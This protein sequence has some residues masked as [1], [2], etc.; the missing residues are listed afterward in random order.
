MATGQATAGLSTAGQAKNAEQSELQRI[1][2]RIN[3]VRSR[4]CDL[5]G[6]AARIAESLC[7]ENPPETPDDKAP[8]EV[9]SGHLGVLENNVDDLDKQ[10]DHLTRALARITNGLKV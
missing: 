3:S 8:Q 2:E 7:G 9:R 10:V 6:I 5:T 1:T 4:C